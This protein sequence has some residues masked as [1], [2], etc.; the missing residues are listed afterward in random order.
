MSRARTLFA[1]GLSNRPYSVLH[2]KRHEARTS[3]PI[4]AELADPLVE[5]CHDSAPLRESQRKI[6][7][8]GPFIPCRLQGYET[9]RMSV[10]A[11]NWIAVSAA[12]TVVLVTG[13]GDDKQKAKD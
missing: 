9:R 1:R 8:L 10:G 6:R 12:L 3:D 5:R 7:R 11:R 2:R 13:C 4:D